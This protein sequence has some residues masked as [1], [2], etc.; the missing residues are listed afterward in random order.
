MGRITK[1]DYDF[2]ILTRL[3]VEEVSARDCPTP[4][5]QENRRYGCVSTVDSNSCL[6][7]TSSSTRVRKENST[8]NTE[9]L[10][11]KPEKLDFH[12][13]IQQLRRM[14]CVVSNLV[15]GGDGLILIQNRAVN[16][17]QIDV[18]PHLNVFNQDIAT[19]IKLATFEEGDL[20]SHIICHIGSIILAQL[21]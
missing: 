4:L 1:L 19:Y 9:R 18:M 10:G 14:L 6:W 11:N 17:Q 20:S 16:I 13:R 5:L 15:A 7:N 2:P 21:G 3:F 8:N 12:G